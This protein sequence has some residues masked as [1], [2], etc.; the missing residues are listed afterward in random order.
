MRV[1]AQP[2]GPGPTRAA[3]SAVVTTVVAVMPV[4]L[5]GGLAV[6]ISR[7]LAM[8]TP[9]LGLAVAVYFGAT[10]LES[11]PVGL[12]VERL[13]SAVTARIGILLAAA[14]MVGIASWARSLPVLLGLLAVAATANSLGQ[15]SS[16]ALLGRRVRTGRQGVAFGVKQAAIPLA[17]LLG[18]AAVPTV[19]LTVGWRWAFLAGAAC[20]LPAF[21]LVPRDPAVRAS[22][23]RR[24]RAR[25]GG[26]LVALGI[27]A[28]LGASAATSVS[29][30]LV[31]SAVAAG[32]SEATAGLMLSLGAGVCVVTRILI[33]AV[34]DRWRRGHLALVAGLLSAGALGV[35]VLGQDLGPESTLLGV[36]LG[37]GLGWSFPGLLTFAVVRLNPQAPAAATSVTQTGLHAGNCLGPLAFGLLASQFGF[38][39]AWSAAGTAM[40]LS[41]Y[42]VLLGA[43]RAERAPGRVHPST[44][45]EA[46]RIDREH[47][48]PG[49]PKP[50]APRRAGRLG[51]VQVMSLELVALAAA[52]TIFAFPSVPLAATGVA[53]AVLLL[54]VV[55]RYRDR[56]WYEAVGAWL[57]LRGRRSDGARAAVRARAAGPY[58]PDLATLA[59]RLVLR[60]VS[61][62]ERSF[63]VGADHLGWF[64]AVAIISPDGMSRREQASVRLDWITRLADPFTA[65]QVVVR[66][67]PSAH[68]AHSAHSG[69]PS[70]PSAES[71]R[72]LREAL[73]ITRQRDV[74]VAVRIGQRDVASLGDERG[75]D[76][77]HG[78][79]GSTLAR[80]S[81]ALTSH[82]IDHRVLD[83]PGLRQSLLGAYGPEP[84]DPRLARARR[85]ARESWGLVRT[86]RT[87]HVCYGVTRWPASAP[88]DL[89]AQL[90]DLPGATA[91]CTSVVTGAIRRPQDDEGP[92][93]ARV[94][95]RV[96]ATSDKA[97]RSLRHLRATA[98]RLGVGLVRL[99]GEQAPALYATMPT[100]AAD[101]RSW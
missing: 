100:A 89:L 101:G 15:L 73:G 59:P 84:Y 24:P 39:L 97:T 30:F 78:L 8:S 90:T 6:Q 22:R 70:S 57:A 37:Y 47:G 45:G 31:A 41:A 63:G 91:V 66:H 79:L 25:L 11:V 96:V 38:M 87:V 69:Q 81:E 20:C 13:G 28:F 65:V 75:C 83:V 56:W 92:L 51:L 12:L 55:A 36:A 48:A 98:R 76:A 1:A 77:I 93:E 99:D 34:G 46:E 49:V 54:P 85:P 17:T 88:P 94:L 7:D 19:A 68:P 33:G 40:A 32:N 74:W 16:N 50:K 44:P 82:G 3:T 42:F 18:G 71:D 35:T 4:F 95:I 14:S 62:R 21:A 58:W 26:S 52:A 29:T 86:G 60:T 23:A 53:S 72:A 64:A 43:R 10:A 27:A 80:I 9:Q 2:G 5:V 67:M 61:H